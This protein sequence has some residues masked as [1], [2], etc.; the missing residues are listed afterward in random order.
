M[1]G[2]G[3]AHLQS[4][5][6]QVASVGS[7][8]SLFGVEVGFVQEEAT[9][10]AFPHGSHGCSVLCIQLEHLG[11]TGAELYQGQEWLSELGRGLGCR[12]WVCAFLEVN[13]HRAGEARPA[14][15]PREPRWLPRGR[16]RPGSWSLMSFPITVRQARGHP[17]QSRLSP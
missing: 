5:P 15:A 7:L 13:R 1:R 2:A 8:T 6:H 9:A 14:G 4:H 12:R 3:G 11:L 16:H 10:L 17:P